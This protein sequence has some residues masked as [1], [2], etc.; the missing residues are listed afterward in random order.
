[1]FALR[2][3]LNHD[4][5]ELA[6]TDIAIQGFGNVGS[7][8]AR[9]L[10]EEGATITA[11]SDITG[12]YYDPTGLDIPTVYEH[13]AAEGDLET[14][15]DATE[16]TNAEL[17]TLDCDVLMPAAIGHVLTEDNA[18]DVQAEY[19]LEGANGPTTYPAHQILQNRGV[20][21]IP[22]IFANA[23][24]V[25]VSYFEWAQNIQHF[26]WSESEIND[27]L[28]ERFVTAHAALQETRETYD[29]SMRTAAFVN[30]IERVR[31]ATE[32][33]GLQ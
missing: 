25:T 19:V 2:E 8:A 3:V 30:A 17:L 22:D 4:G 24:G 23:G 33:R 9:L 28:E 12:G 1:M 29:V 10:H 31:H 26:S 20:T 21:C 5:R 14:F 6:G 13:V 11:V 16:I 18:D 27:Q 32:M 7:W 15:D